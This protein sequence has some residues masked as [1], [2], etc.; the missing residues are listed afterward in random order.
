MN[1]DND[2]LRGSIATRIQLNS[3]GASDIFLTCPELPN[4][5][6]YN[7][8]DSIMHY[9]IN[10]ENGLPTKND[11]LIKN[12]EKIL[13]NTPIDK[14][15]SLNNLLPY[16]ISNERDGMTARPLYQPNCVP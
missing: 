12:K 16:N 13:D 4:A 6:A 1:V 10:N 15:P 7:T 11:V 14:R 2:V 5:Y 8:R 3:L 9:F